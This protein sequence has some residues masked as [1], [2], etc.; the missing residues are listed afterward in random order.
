MS[1]KTYT[2]TI[3]FCLGL[4]ATSPL[5]AFVMGGR[6]LS[7]MTLSLM[8]VLLDLILH[9]SKKFRGT[10]NSKLF[11][12]FMGWM[13]ISILA[14]AFGFLYFSNIDLAY[15][16]S[17]LKHIPKILLYIFSAL[18]LIVTKQR[19]K[20]ISYI[21]NGI[22]W[23]IAINLIWSIADAGL[24]YTT[25]NSLTNQV[26]SAY[27]SATD[28]HHGMA[29][30]VD[31]FTIRSVGLNNDPATIGFF[32]TIAAAYSFLMK[33][34]WI[35]V[36]GVIASFACV[37]FVGLVGIFFVALFHLF[38]KNQVK[39]VINAVILAIV[40]IIGYNIIRENELVQDISFALE[41][42]AN[43]K[44]EGDHSSQ[45]RT[46]FFKKFPNAI[47]NMPV[48]L[49]LG[50]GYSTAVYPYYP[51]GLDYGT[52]PHPT[53]MENTYVDN[54]F[55]FGLIGFV[56]FVWFYIKLYSISKQNILLNFNRTNQVLY[57]VSLASLISFLFYHYTLYSVVM[58]VSVCGIVYYA[59]QPAQIVTDEP[60][61]EKAPSLT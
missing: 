60:V 35:L 41:Q 43:S 24:Y 61:N 51:E 45:T 39:I 18:L 21:L 53:Y 56:L 10:Y 58:L 17:S 44:I 2:K 40:L 5:M 29:S 23:G 52:P 25:R 11:N 32:A 12:L 48:S 13:G 57:S 9:H 14:S 59:T 19:D 1:S 16:V 47:L 26:F 38:R 6:V 22:Y 7:L 50:T 28:M 42:R 37:S 27:I 46:L 33:R 34:K 20:K 3:Y 4:G 55:S 54:F 31:G 15:S 36:L 8:L 30:L 49:L